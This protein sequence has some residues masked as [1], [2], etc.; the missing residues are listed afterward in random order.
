[1]PA[2]TAP[3]T[4][5]TP[6][7]AHNP[8]PSAADTSTDRSLNPSNPHPRSTTLHP[9]Q[10]MHALAT[11]I[12]APTPPRVHHIAP[13]ATNIPTARNPNPHPRCTTLHPRPSSLPFPIT[14]PSTRSSAVG[15]L[16][17]AHWHPERRHLATAPHN[18]IGHTAHQAFSPTFLIQV[19]PC[20]VNQ[21]PLRI[22]EQF[23][24]PL[25]VFPRLC[26]MPPIVFHSD[27]PL[28]KCK[29][30]IIAL[31]RTALIRNINRHVDRRTRQAVTLQQKPHLCLGRRIRPFTHE[32]QCT[33][34]VAQ[35]SRRGQTFILKVPLKFAHPP[36]EII[37]RQPSHI[38]I[39]AHHRI[40]EQHEFRQSHIRC[41]H[42]PRVKRG[43]ARDA[44]TGNGF[45]RMAPLYAPQS[46]HSSARRTRIRE[47]DKVLG[48]SWLRGLISPA[49]RGRTLRRR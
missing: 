9:Q 6:P 10:Q 2:P 40:T 18:A 26:M 4:T 38:G 1:M 27:A 35:S 20:H 44:A 45:H 32:A 21:Q 31:S 34:A 12:A 33:T 49:I 43:D 30:K 46:S 41:K 48:W 39:A 13:S 47:Y 5:P 36:I 3:I 7:R 11:P 23:Y 17:Q 37:K 28:R 8:A 42:Q 24:A 25:I 16:T 29:V 15:Q 22:A 14:Q 19:I